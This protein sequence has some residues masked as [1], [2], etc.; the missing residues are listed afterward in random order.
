MVFCLCIIF[1]LFSRHL[2]SYT[3]STKFAKIIGIHQFCLHP[4]SSHCTL[5][6]DVKKLQSGKCARL[7]CCRHRLHSIGC[8]AFHQA[9][10]M[11]V[12]HLQDK[13]HKHDR[14][15]ETHSNFLLKFSFHS[16]FLL[17][18][19]KHLEVAKYSLEFKHYVELRLPYNSFLLV[20]LLSFI[21]L[22]TQ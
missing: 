15:H 13:C 5:I 11:F 12:S 14:C 1:V 2:E 16:S 22:D 4:P 18:V 8:T 6:K 19:L 7:W 9:S 3:Y 21:R 17:K 20:P 10:R